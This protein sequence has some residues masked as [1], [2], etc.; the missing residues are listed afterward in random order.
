MCVCVH[1]VCTC[2]VCVHVVCVC[3]W[4]ACGVCVHVVC[5]CRCIGTCAK[6]ECANMKFE[7]VSCVIAHLVCCATGRVCCV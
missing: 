5:V 6:C 7:F 3:M 2:V 1:V 4:C